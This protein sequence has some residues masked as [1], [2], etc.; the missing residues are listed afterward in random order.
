MP[1][2]TTPAVSPLLNQRLLAYAIAAAG[3]VSLVPNVDAQVIYTPANTIL[4]EGTLT[5]DLNQ[6]GTQDFF[7]QNSRTSSSYNR[8]AFLSVGGNVAESPAVLGLINAEQA[9]AVPKGTRIGSDSPAK[10]IAVSSRLLASMASVRVKYHGWKLV[11]HW[12]NVG[13]KYLGFQFTLSDGVHYGWA[14]LSVAARTQIVPTTVAKLT[15]FAF[16]AT[17]NQS[18]VAGDRGFSSDAV[19]ANSTQAGPS[20]GIL[21]LGAATRR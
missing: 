17:P 5:I 4:T 7:L 13:D 14:R 12:A 6:D 8:G 18:I 20:L 1:K 21:S 9:F 10:F 3:A 16:E 2:A 11:G 19:S 15:G